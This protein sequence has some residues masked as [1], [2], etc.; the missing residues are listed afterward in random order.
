MIGHNP[1]FE[2][3]LRLL[4]SHEERYAHAGATARF[5]T[6]GLAAIDLPAPSWREASPGSGSLERF[7]TPKSLGWSDAE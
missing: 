6:A 4:L 1:G 7:V 2:E 3:L 5:P